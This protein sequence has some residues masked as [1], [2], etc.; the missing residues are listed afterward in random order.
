M[1]MVSCT[2][3]LSRRKE[4]KKMK[5]NF[6]W[7]TK[8][9]AKLKAMYEEGKSYTEMAKALKRTKSAITQKLYKRKK[10]WGQ[11]VEVAQPQAVVQEEVVE[12]TLPLSNHLILISLGA[13]VGFIVGLFAGGYL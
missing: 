10:D 8:E 12:E 13:T 3:H 1:S 11:K 2:G 4:K 7:T 5:A 6:R 9:E